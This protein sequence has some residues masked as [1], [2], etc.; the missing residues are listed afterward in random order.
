M[1]AD[2]FVVFGRPARVMNI[3]ILVLYVND[4][5]V[6]PLVGRVLHV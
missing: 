5:S 3:E 6:D 4:L 1:Y 2:I